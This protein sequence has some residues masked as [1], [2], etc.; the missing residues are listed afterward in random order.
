VGGDLKHYA[1]NNAGE[2][3]A[4]PQLPLGTT[5][6]PSLALGGA[7]AAW[8]VVGYQ[9]RCDIP[10]SSE[11]ETTFW[12]EYLLFNRTQG[13]AFLV[14]SN[15]GWSWVKPIT[16]APSVGGDT[17]RWQ[18]AVYQKKWSYGA[19][20][21]WVQGEFYWRVKRDER[22]HVMDFEGQGKDR[23]KRLSREQAGQEVTW[24]AGATISAATVADAFGIAPGARAALQRDVN[25][26]AGISG[27]VARG[28]II[29]AVVIVLLIILV[30]CSRDS[31][32]DV[33]NTFGAAST[34]YQQCSRS[35][36]SGVRGG[37]GG[38]YGGYSSGGGGHK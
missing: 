17:A 10:D 13:F 36:G 38:S 8:Q 22:A 21:T 28:L 20:V 9:E 12:R 7:P 16:G 18:G 14:D 30:T 24:S 19:K 6:Q 34:E 4:E 5:S 3:G 11:E 29:F 25:P 32:D 33:R 2:R 27:G 23:D 35:S 31:C 15:D 37:S 26:V 1:Q